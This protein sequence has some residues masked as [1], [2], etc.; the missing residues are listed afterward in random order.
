MQ[1]ILVGKVQIARVSA[2]SAEA[3]TLTRCEF[4]LLYFLLIGQ[5]GQDFERNLLPSN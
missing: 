5:D 2:G 3:P 1:I 4:V